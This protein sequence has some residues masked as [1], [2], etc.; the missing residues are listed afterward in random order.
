MGIF[1]CPGYA[2]SMVLPNPTTLQQQASDPAVSVWVAANAGSGKTKVL[3]DRVLRLLLEGVSP[4]HILCLTY[5]KAGAS[6]MLLRVSRKTREWAVMDDAALTTELEALSGTA[7]STEHITMARGLFYGLVDAAPGLRILTIHAFC[8]QVLAQFPQEAGISMQATVMED[9][10]MFELVAQARRAVMREAHRQPGTPLAEAIHTLSDWLSEYRFEEI[11]R[12]IRTKHWEYHPIIRNQAT[13]EQAVST[14]YQ[15]AGCSQDETE[16]S[17]A[18]A[19][20]LHDEAYRATLHACASFMLEHGS[21]ND[22]KYIMPLVECLKHPY[23]HDRFHQLAIGLLT[24]NFTVRGKFPTNA[25][26]KAGGEHVCD[27]IQHLMTKCETYVRHW[28]TLRSTRL[29]HATMVI[30]EAFFRQ[31]ATLKTQS[32]L[33]DYDDLIAHTLA[34]LEDPATAPWVLYKLDGQ[35]DHLLI[36]EAQ[37]TSLQQWRITE[38]LSEE[39]FAGMGAQ[40]DRRRLFVVGDD[41]QSIYSFQGAAPKAFDAQRRY[42]AA[43]AESAGHPFRHVPMQTSFRSSDAVLDVVDAFCADEEVRQAVSSHNE[44]IRHHAHRRHTPGGVTLHP[45]IITERP[46]KRQ[47][48]QR[49][50]ELVQEDTGRKQLAAQVADHI[51]AMLHPDYRHPAT[52]KPVKAG[53]ILILV[54]TRSVLPPLLNQALSQRNI[55]TAGQDRVRLNQHIA[56]KDL[57]ALGACLIDPTDDAALAA[58]LTSPLFNLTY[59]QLTELCANRDDG[60]TV[61]QRLQH[62]PNHASIIDEFRRLQSV[63]AQATPRNLYTRLCFAH[64][65][66]HRFAARMGESVRDILY[67]FLHACETYEA[68]HHAVSLLGFLTWMQQNNS[69]IKQDMEQAG[70][71]VRIMTIHGAKGLEA[72]I[73]I[74]P[75]TCGTPDDM[76]REILLP[77][78]HRETPLMLFKDGKKDSLSGV[79]RNAY[80]KRKQELYQESLRLL[81][82]AMTRACDELHVF[83]TP[84]KGGSSVQEGCWYWHLQQAMQRLNVEP[85]EN[86]TLAYRRHDEQQ[87]T[88]ISPAT[89]EPPEPLPAH[90]LI[91]VTQAPIQAPFQ[92]PS[93]LAPPTP[94][95]TQP[96]TSIETVSPLTAAERGTLMHRCL[97]WQ[98]GMA[99]EEFLRRLPGFI[100]HLCPDIPVE[101]QDSIVQ[102]LQRLNQHPD[103][104]ALLELPALAEAP[105]CGT[106]ADG[107]LISGQIDRLIITESAVT[108]L[109]IKTGAP[110]A[111]S[112]DA[113]EQYRMQMDAYQ[114][115]VVQ[116]YPALPVTCILLYVGNDAAIMAL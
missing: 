30:A 52:G 101:A 44:D 3:V 41:K 40:G 27:E 114:Q 78:T 99:Y 77:A 4:S 2:A 56:V 65:G 21:P 9:A 16:E 42:Y 51:V 66:I 105:I 87:P 110:P 96:T 113:P 107:T 67:H 115:L 43:L 98:C 112:E 29:S 71:E 70:E 22:K 47:P 61:W 62:H 76:R 24:T 60:E 90:L 64:H 25:I 28:H 38:R 32:N 63:A 92:A 84:E 69:D 111:S 50:D 82:V 7:P 19:L 49:V 37:D 72:P 31:Y 48:W 75:D 74:L 97:E 12:E 35:I 100:R 94:A 102:D 91:P 95:I 53:D 55:P 116:L 20:G 17:L 68:S 36:D 11:I 85:L 57:L 80:D 6:E 104:I 73:V 58:T 34:L 89:H 10:Q 8:Q 103:I 23:S 109:D 93:T 45:L 1:F 86:D 54:R 81:Y 39:F 13:L 83:G 14:L 18:H 106:L 26:R 79:F 46:P 5:T 88:E 15:A 33:M 108:I 59:D